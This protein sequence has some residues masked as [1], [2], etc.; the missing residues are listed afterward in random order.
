[1]IPPRR[2]LITG[3]V[4]VLVA[5]LWWRLNSDSSAPTE[6]DTAAGPLL[7]AY[8]R[9]FSLLSTDATGQPA[10]RLRAPTA[11]YYDDPGLWQLDAPRWQVMTESGAPWIGRSDQARSWD[12]N[13]QAQLQGNVQLSRDQADGQV[14]L[15]TQTMNL[16]LPTRYAHTDEP[17]TL[18]GPGYR[19]AATGAKAWLD[20]QRI[21]LL[22]KARGQY[23]R[24]KAAP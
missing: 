15:R 11:R 20:E 22:N 16:E 24:S 12:D 9:E 13:E 4:F 18:T 23:A 21:E 2:I 17:V 10:Y 14:L 1:M 6:P 8:A 3:L 5:L 19:V 7:S